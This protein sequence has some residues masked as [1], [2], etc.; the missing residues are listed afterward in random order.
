M[1]TNKKKHRCKKIRKGVYEYRGVT[2][3][4]LG[5]YEPDHRVVWEGSCDGSFGD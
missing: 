3:E 4:C 5:Y 2:I 1:E